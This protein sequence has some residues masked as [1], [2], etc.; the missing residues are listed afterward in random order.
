MTTPTDADRAKLTFLRDAWRGNDGAEGD[1]VRWLCDT[2]ERLADA[3][4][5]AE[6]KL[7]ELEYVCPIPRRGQTFPERMIE[8]VVELGKFEQE[9]NS[10]RS[11]CDR[12][13]AEAE[14]RG[15][16]NVLL[17]LL[18]D[19]QITGGLAAELCGK[20]IAEM[21]SLLEAF[22]KSN[23]HAEVA[24]G[25]PHQDDGGHQWQ[26]VMGTGRG[27]LRCV[28]CKEVRDNDADDYREPCPARAP[29]PHDFSAQGRNGL[30]CA[31]PGCGVECG[32]ESS[33]VCPDPSR[34]PKETP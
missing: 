25:L 7:E 33:D 24:S 34:A 29:K 22:R 17:E 31:N 15:R 14:E 20:S 12:R 9:C 5:E 16:V 32:E 1:A 18:D 19:E 26:A 23:P 3:R 30:Y 28:Q 11:E 2:V 27:K 21:V 6:R 13:V 8:Y 4:A 10:L